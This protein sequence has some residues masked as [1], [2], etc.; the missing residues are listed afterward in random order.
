MFV[1]C[2]WCERIHAFYISQSISITEVNVDT[3]TE[4]DDREWIAENVY[5]GT[6][7]TESI[8]PT[9]NKASDHSLQYSDLIEYADKEFVSKLFKRTE[10]ES[11]NTILNNIVLTDLTPKQL[12]KVKK[13]FD[14]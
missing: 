9:C 12:L 3:I 14:L 2:K 13:V 1:Y 10:D 7:N 5:E 11:S 4:R 6:Y 8:C